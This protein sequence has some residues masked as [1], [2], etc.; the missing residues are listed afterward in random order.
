MLWASSKISMLPSTSAAGDGGGQGGGG[1]AGQAL[2]R[3]AGRATGEGSGQGDG[4]RQRAVAL[5]QCGGAYAMAARE[6]GPNPPTILPA[7]ATHPRS[8][9]GG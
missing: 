8:L 4:R 9:R 6:P 3:A 7:A 2:G 5:A 1:A